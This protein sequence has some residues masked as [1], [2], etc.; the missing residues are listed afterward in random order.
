MTTLKT[1]L[2]RGGLVSFEIPADWAEEYEEDGGG[3]FYSA[4]PNAGTL[5][6]SV[7]TAKMDGG[8][9]ASIASRQTITLAER[10]AAQEVGTTPVVTA[11]P[12]GSVVSYFTCPGSRA[13]ASSLR[14]PGEDN[15]RPLTMHRWLLGAGLQPDVMRL[16]SFTYAVEAAFDADAGN[17]ADVEVIDAAIKRA[18]FSTTTSVVPGGN[19]PTLAV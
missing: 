10:S 2:Y 9:D 3:T 13:G 4:R 17:V 18:V 1:I 14:C 8:I 6:L 11:L 19:P 12:N 5:Y 16:A 7:I 15:G